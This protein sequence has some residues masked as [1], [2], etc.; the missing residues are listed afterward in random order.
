MLDQINTTEALNAV[1]AEVAPPR[2]NLSVIAEGL[3][4]L[5]DDELAELDKIITPRAAELLE[6]AF[7]KEL[8]SII[9]PLYLND[10]QATGNLNASNNTD[11][12]NEL[13][14]IIRDPKYWRDH[15]PSLVAKVTE[16]Y[17]R[18]YP[19]K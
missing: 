9:G 8:L 11:L 5:S 18:L 17:A 6:K 16:G 7:G 10:N 3:S 4:S 19:N 13:R 15:E 12:E 14:N 2:L 1:P